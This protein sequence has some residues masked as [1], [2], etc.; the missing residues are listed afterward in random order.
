MSAAVGI[1]ALQAFNAE[2]D[3][4]R[5]RQEASDSQ[6]REQHERRQQNFVR[7][8][9]QLLKDGH[10][11][12][13][14]V[15]ILGPRASVGTIKAL[16]ALAKGQERIRKEQSGQAQAGDNL[17]ALTQLIAEAR[18]GD[19]RA[20]Q[21]VGPVLRD[22]ARLGQNDP[23]I[24]AGL[25][26]ALDVGVPVAQLAEE[27]AQAADAQTLRTTALKD[28]RDLRKFKFGDEGTL[29]GEHIKLSKT[30]I[31]Q[32][33]AFGRIQAAAS[34]PSQAGDLALIFNFM[35]LLDPGSVVRES[36]F[37]TAQNAAN[38]PQR[39][40]GIYN[41]TLT[42]KRLP[43]AQ[44]KDFVARADKLFA[45]AEKDQSRLDT[46]FRGLAKRNN[47]SPGNVVLDFRPEIVDA[48]GG[49]DTPSPPQGE[50]A[51]T[52]VMWD[53]KTGFPLFRRPNGSIFDVTPDETL[54]GPPSARP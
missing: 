6:E 17:G 52:F 32:R 2:T 37:A 20:A 39:I 7:I 13:E 4:R 11:S 41:R 44:R 14:M 23:T 8:G 34:D 3:R 15:D 18:L 38:V 22:T 26:R 25:R 19:T 24:Q 30:F 12:K 29:R 42:G 36:E 16:S 5:A 33:N 10:N 51:A 45:Q 27:R 54:V 35:K 21:T 9:T 46:Q 31:E 50:E 28:S 43:D 47:L 40:Q 48:K 53:K 49:K 1:R